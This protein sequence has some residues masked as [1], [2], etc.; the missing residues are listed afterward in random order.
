MITLSNTYGHDGT[1]HA[2]FSEN[3]FKHMNAHPI[4]RYQEIVVLFAVPIAAVEFKGDHDF[5]DR[6][7]TSEMSRQ[8]SLVACTSRWFYR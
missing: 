7:L 5:I 6:E 3:Q 4:C 2:K 1:F 8:L